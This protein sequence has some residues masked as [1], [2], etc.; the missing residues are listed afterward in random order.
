MYMCTCMYVQIQDPAKQVN[1]LSVRPQNYLGLTFF[2]LLCC[3]CW[4]GW[5]FA[6]IGFVFSVQVRKL[7]QFHWDGVP[8]KG[9]MSCILMYLSQVDNQY[10]NKDFLGAQRSSKLARN[11]SI[12]AIATGL[13]VFFIYCAFW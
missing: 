3:C 7:S 2:A 1:G 12:A 11:W 10:T 6:I 8:I 5:I 9:I 13:A 4:P